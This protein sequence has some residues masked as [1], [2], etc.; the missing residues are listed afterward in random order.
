MNYDRQ[1]EDKD[2]WA[3]YLGTI[4]VGGIKVKYWLGFG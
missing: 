2:S 1:H 3:H 4:G